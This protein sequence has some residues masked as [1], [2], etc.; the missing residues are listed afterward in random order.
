[1]QLRYEGQGGASKKRKIDEA[2]SP[3]RAGKSVSVFLDDAMRSI[4]LMQVHAGRFQHSW[5][6]QSPRISRVCLEGAC[7]C[8]YLLAES[9]PLPPPSSLP[10]HSRGQDAENGLSEI[11]HCVKSDLVF[12][13]N[14]IILKQQ[15][16]LK[17][18]IQHCLQ[19]LSKV[20]IWIQ[21]RA[22][23]RSKTQAFSI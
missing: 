7:S 21:V 17:S 15:E 13:C 2:A 5:V 4:L 19:M 16:I 8:M 23:G 14:E 20:K 22:P 18:E 3:R 11:S 10:A 9:P 12:E 6:T 1:M